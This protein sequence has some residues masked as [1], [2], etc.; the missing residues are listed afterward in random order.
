M[1]RHRRVSVKRAAIFTLVIAIVCFVLAIAFLSSGNSIGGG[2][3]FVACCF[4]LVP[5]IICF[6]RHRKVKLAIQKSENRERALSEITDAVIKDLGIDDCPDDICKRVKYDVS[7]FVY[8]LSDKEIKRQKENP[9]AFARIPYCCVNSPDS[10]CVLIH[11]I[12]IYHYLNLSRQIEEI[13]VSSN[14]LPVNWTLVKKQ[15]FHIIEE[16]LKNNKNEP[17]NFNSEEFMEQIKNVLIKSTY[18]RT[19]EIR[20]NRKESKEEQGT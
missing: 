12:F 10:L 11:S 15:V 8:Y 13:R 3:C 14:I 6:N 9:N 1:L 20:I 5:A 2:I 17:L 4:F 16:Q 7:H 19:G 18:I